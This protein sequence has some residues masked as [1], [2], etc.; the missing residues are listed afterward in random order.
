MQRSKSILPLVDL[1]GQ[2]FGA[3]QIGAGLLGFF[4]LGALGE[5]RDAQACGRCRSAAR[6]RRAPSGRH[7]AGST[8]RLMRQ[9]D[10]LVEL[11]GGARLHQLHR[12]FDRVAL[13]AID[14]FD[15]SSCN[16]WRLPWRLVPHLDAHRAGGALDHA[17]SRFR[18]RWR[19]GPSSWPR[20][21]RAPGRVVTLPATV[22]ARRLGARRRASPPS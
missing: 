20:R 11:G 4:G 15:G 5:H 22:D 19:S 17:A 13:V 14:A 8:P 16:A 7:G 3:D 18:C 1:L 10:G 2:I 6:P 12:F 9:F 21:S